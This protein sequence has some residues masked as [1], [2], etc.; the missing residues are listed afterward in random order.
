MIRKL[1]SIRLTF[2]CI[3]SL[4]ALLTAG[5]LIYNAPDGREAIERLNGMLLFSW[6]DH[7]LQTHLMVALWVLLTC[8]VAGLLLVNTLTCSVTTLLPPALK[9][10][11][12]KRWSFFG[13]HILF[14]V[15]LCCH[16]IALI[17]GH[18]TENITLFQGESHALV[19]GLILHVSKTIYI[20]DMTL[21]TR[22]KQ[23]RRKMM[24]RE[25]FHY[26]ENGVQVLLMTGKAPVASGTVRFLEPL[27]YGSLRITLTNFSVMNEKN[28]DRKPKEIVQNVLDTEGALELGERGATEEI[29]NNIGAVFTVTENAFTSVFFTA[30]GLLILAIVGFIIATTEA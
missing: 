24:T 17:N 18:K 14:I 26:K 12:L 4:G 23:E 19:D 1:A 9:R 20:D 29:K 30:Y 11:T 21:L 15:V 22:P 6:M 27:V 13:I 25:A 2:V 10:S 7:H 28:V 16:G 8:G 3:I 5:I